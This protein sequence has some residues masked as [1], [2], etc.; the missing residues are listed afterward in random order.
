MQ[1]PVAVVGEGGRDR[2]AHHLHQPVG[3]V[4]GEAAH[5]VAEQVAIRCEAEAL[6]QVYVT[7]SAPVKRLL[8]SQRWRETAEQRAT[9]LSDAS[10]ISTK[11]VLR[12]SFVP[13]QSAQTG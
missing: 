2:A 1:T 10:R 7:L 9:H 3:D 4:I 6:S 13:P 5:P 11:E 8:W 12:D